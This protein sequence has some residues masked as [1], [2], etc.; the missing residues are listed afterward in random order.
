M[1]FHKGVHGVTN[2]Q[3]KQL[4]QADLD[5]QDK[6]GVKYHKFWMNEET[7][8]IFCL[9]EGPSKEACIAVHGE[10]HGQ[11]A[12]EIIEVQQSDVALFMGI[13][14]TNGA[15]RVVYTDGQYDS[16]VRTF[17]FTDI[18][19]STDLTQQVGD[20]KAI[21]IIRKHNKIVRDNIILN[22]GKEVKHTG[23]GI[24]ASFVSAFKAV[25]CAREIQKNLK[26][27]R[28][29]NPGY[30]LHV[31]IGLNTGEPVTEGGDFFGVT[32]QMAARIC[33][34]AESNQVLVSNIVKELCM[35]K[36]LNFVDRGPMELKG[37]SSPISVYE[38][39]WA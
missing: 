20:A 18:V 29:E 30:P 28:D 22:E 8:T 27:L 7:G 13:A 1:D 24:M 23:D 12:C 9:T 36:T 3:A 37:F 31:R 6:Y 17:L 32:V 2:D 21:E 26:K 19:D 33:N 39:D 10:A 11:M 25:N 35:G 34:K 38:V 16:A 5:V 15:G 14:G 4:H